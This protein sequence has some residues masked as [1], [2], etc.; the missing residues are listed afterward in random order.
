MNRLALDPDGATREE[1]NGKRHL[2]A[3]CHPDDLDRILDESD[4]LDC[5]TQ[6]HSSW[7]CG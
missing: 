3:H 7:K 2:G 1:V 4:A 6:I 5:R